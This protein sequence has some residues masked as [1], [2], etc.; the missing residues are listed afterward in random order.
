MKFKHY[1]VVSL[2]FFVSFGATGNAAAESGS[3]P[4]DWNGF[5]R[6]NFQLS[7]VDCF[8]VV[9]NDT[10]EGKPWVWRARFPSYHP[11]ADRILL[12]KG[13]H[14]AHLNTAGMLGSTRSLELWDAF[15]ELITDE[16]GLA[17]KPALEAVSRGALFTYRWAARHPDRVSCIYADTPVCDIKRESGDR[18]SIESV[19]PASVKQAIA[20]TQHSAK[21]SLQAR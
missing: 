10:A 9:P 16:H 5:Q 2:L 6:F 14:I 8:V 21:S 18:S 12:E 3:D 4:A 13:F 7:D 19:K 15:Y 11:E 20:E 1:S 17:A